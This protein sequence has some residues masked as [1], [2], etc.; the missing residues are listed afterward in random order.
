MPNTNSPS[1]TIEASCQTQALQA[2]TVH[3]SLRCSSLQPKTL[4]D[5]KLQQQMICFHEEICTTFIKVR[6]TSMCAKP[7]SSAIAP[8]SAVNGDEQSMCTNPHLIFQWPDCLQQMKMN[9]HV[10]KFTSPLLVLPIVSVCS[11]VD[12]IIESTSCITIQYTNIGKPWKQSLLLL[13]CNRGEVKKMVQ[14]TFERA[15]EL[16]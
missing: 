15:P 6:C 5:S 9:K 10:C 11:N 7:S 2:T 4:S 14:K 13:P 1:R 3:E 12:Q 16:F 8:F